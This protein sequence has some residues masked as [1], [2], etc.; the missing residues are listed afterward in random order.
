MNNRA[1]K[2]SSIE[3]VGNELRA[4]NDDLAE[5]AKNRGE[6]F[7]LPQSTYTLRSIEFQARN[8]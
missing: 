2:V 5:W 6:K 3:H 4:G 1:G 7:F 8:L